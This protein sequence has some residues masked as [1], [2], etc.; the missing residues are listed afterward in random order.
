MN[1][2][3]F[4]I[5]ISLFS[6]SYIVNAQNK[7]VD[8]LLA[9]LDKTPHDTVKIKIYNQLANIYTKKQPEISFDY[10]KKSFELSDKLI[11]SDDDELARAAKYSQSVSYTYMGNYYKVLGDYYSAKE[12][13]K[14]SIEIRQELD[15]KNGIA[16]NYID[17][18]IINTLKGEYI[19]A[20]DNY[21]KALTIQEEVNNQTLLT[22]IYRNMGNVYY[23]QGDYPSA[24]EHYQKSLALS[25]KLNDLK[26]ASRCYNNIGYIHM[27]NNNYDWAIDYYKK[28]LQIK[29]Q[30]GDKVSLAT[31]YNNIGTVYLNKHEFDSAL[32]YYKESLNLRKEVKAKRDMAISLQNIGKVYTAKQQFDEAEKHYLNSL[33]I[34]EN[35]EDNEQVSNLLNQLGFLYLEQK[36]YNK[37]IEFAKKSLKIAIELHAL[38]RQKDAYKILSSAYEQ[39]R[40]LNKAFYYLKDYM[41]VKD[42]I[43]ERAAQR[44]I[45]S[46]TKY[47]IGKKEKELEAKEREIQVQEL[48]AKNQKMRMYFMVSALLVMIV[49]AIIFFR[50][51]KQKLK[52]NE[53][54]RAQKEEIEAQKEEIEKHRDLVVEQN[55]IVLEQKKEITD[56]IHYA[57][58]IQRAVMP[59]NELM[60]AILPDYFMML[61]PK[62]IVSGDFYWLKKIKNFIVIAVA[63]CTGHGVPGAFM[64]MLGSLFLNETVTARSLDSAGEILN[65]VRE[66]I[67]KSLHQ[68]GKEGEAKDG[69]DM[70]FMIYDTES[71]EIQYAGAFNPL[72]IIRA[73]NKIDDFEAIEQQGLAVYH[74]EEYDYSVL[75]IKADRQPIAIYSYEKDFSNHRFQL[76]EDD[77]IYAF[78]DGY[79]DQFGGDKGKK[80][81]ARNF[82][83][84][85]L[86]CQDKNMKE[87][88]EF[89]QKS[90]DQWRGEYEQTDDVVLFGMRVLKK[91]KL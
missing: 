89:M 86:S 88:K 40:N 73:N 24:I 60:D 10:L 70:A 63:D 91:N 30:L 58:N 15:D 87:Q 66:K 22:K 14:K 50:N 3:Y 45:E 4:I 81:K 61:L 12:N 20:E 76:Q 28:S 84:L 1:F 7:T 39:K 65:I 44:L 2:K 49:L 64:S 47:K 11:N 51:Y 62:D 35:I 21:K 59:S 90:F 67:K 17:L 5:L 46:E 56:S 75:E 18:G 55:K 31:A 54:L 27:L 37:A 85:I 82:K 69:M 43:Q 19:D 79:P 78:S 36:K 6:F 72:Y 42:S 32:V 33:K 25:E 29:K 74:P 41:A 16:W 57:E 23:Y 13:Y 68:S 48:N 52:A 34:N 83:K 80:L 53:L 9:E 38:P 8:S 71:L 77:R 26:S